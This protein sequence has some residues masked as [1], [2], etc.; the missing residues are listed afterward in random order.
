M[1]TIHPGIDVSDALVARLTEWQPAEVIATWLASLP[2]VIDELVGSRELTFADV[3]PEPS[4]AIVLFAQSAVHG[5]VLLKLTPPGDEVT[6]GIAG[7]R[8][9]HG[10]GIVR[11]IDADASVSW[12]LLERIFPGTPLKESYVEDEATS[13]TAQ[14]LRT[15]WRGRIDVPGLIPLEEWFESLTDYA[16]A[17]PDGNGPIPPD[18]F[19][20]A[21]H[22]VERLLIGATER[23]LLHGDLHHDNILSGPDDSWI[24]IDP[25]GLVG[26]RGYDVATYLLNPWN[27]GTQAQY[28]SIARARFE[29]LARELEMERRDLVEWSLAHAVLSISWSVKDE[30]LGDVANELG[31]ARA[32]VDLL[33]EPAWLAG[34]T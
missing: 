4:Y 25:K 3:H 16:R 28:P 30:R 21:W 22:A 10:A 29:Q 15:Y 19:R 31:A 17:H 26:P 18:L 1:T 14:S 20:P 34:H 6:A 32:F 24:V 11:L 8:A 9:A 27:I 12:V 23:V 2:P 7:L 33:G 5:D 13:L